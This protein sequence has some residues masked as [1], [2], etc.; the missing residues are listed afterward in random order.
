[1]VRAARR[2]ECGDSNCVASPAPARCGGVVTLAMVARALAAAAYRLGADAPAVL[3]RFA[4]AFGS[5]VRAA[6]GQLATLDPAAQQRLR[7]EWATLA[8]APVPAGIRSV[9]PTW[10]EAGVQGLAARARASV[11]ASG[12]GGPVDVWLARWATANFVAM[13]AV[14]APGTPRTAEA[15][16]LLEGDAALRW[17]ERVGADQFAHAL[18][19]TGAQLPAAIRDASA[20]ILRP[21]RAGQLGPTRAAI[22]RCHV[23][24]GDL[25]AIGANAV[26]PH[27]SPIVRRQIAARLPYDVGVKLWQAFEVGGIAALDRCPTWTALTAS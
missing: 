11:A 24:R 26:A 27:L 15:A 5:D 23:H 1:M 12:V 25:V 20:R 19:S 8:R 10:L 22:E 13:P 17:L 3:Q 16:G 21:P 2:W 9:H 6:A 14:A 4:G 18:A 7:A